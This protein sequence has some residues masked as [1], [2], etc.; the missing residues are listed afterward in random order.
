VSGVV[1][2][3]NARNERS[4]AVTRRLGMRLTDVFTTPTLKQEGHCY[5]LDL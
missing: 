5:R 4:I 1:A 2:M 3:V